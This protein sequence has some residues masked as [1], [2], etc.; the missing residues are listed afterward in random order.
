MGS[1]KISTPCQTN[2]VSA[3][4]RT[5]DKQHLIVV[6]NYVDHSLDPPPHADSFE[7]EARAG[8]IIAFPLLL[9]DMLDAV[10]EDGNAHIVSWQP[11]GRCFVIHKSDEFKKILSKY[12]KLSKIASFQRQLNLYGFSRLTTGPDKGGYYH[13]LFLKGMRWLI[14]GMTRLKVKGTGVRPKSNPSE[15]PNFW[16]MRWVEVGADL[17]NCS[18]CEASRLS[19]PRCVSEQPEDRRSNQ[20]EAP[21]RFDCPPSDYVDTTMIDYGDVA[22]D[23]LSPSEVPDDNE[24]FHL[25]LNDLLFD[26]AEAPL[27]G[28]L[29][30]LVSND[31]NTSP[32]ANPRD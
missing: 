1:H 25:L 27:A 17:Q 5:A 32:Q 22:F 3:V 24:L 8:A 29:E 16:S 4:R 23:H 7:R 11:H 9:H 20:S 21:R 15:E 28:S 30:R 19:S 6:H 10:E 26:T 14:Q 31:E 18:G 13:E 12:F 2:L